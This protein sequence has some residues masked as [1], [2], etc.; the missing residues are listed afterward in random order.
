MRFPLQAFTKL[1]GIPFLLPFFKCRLL[2]VGKETQGRYAR[3]RGGAILMGNHRSMW[4][5]IVMG[6]LFCF[7]ELR[8]WAGEALYE[9]NRLFTWFLNAMGFIR[10]D[11]RVTDL[12][13]I[14]AGVDTVKAGCLL[15]VFPEGRLNHSRE[16]LPF[17]PGVV[18]VALQTGAPILPMYI[19][20]AYGLFRRVRIALGDRIYLRE[21]LRKDIP[22]EEAV[23]ELCRFLEVRMRQLCAALEAEEGSG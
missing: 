15:G 5:P 17:A 14:Q 9:K 3:V 22:H 10:V 12:A 21:H 7:R 20:G 23:R 13:A 18:L 4:D 6:T 8:I 16:L 2:P 19:G 1:T 11:R